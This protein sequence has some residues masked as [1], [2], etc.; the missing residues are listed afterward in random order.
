MNI[1]ARLICAA[2][3][4]NCHCRVEIK[5]GRIRSGEILGNYCRQTQQSRLEL[6]LCV[7]RELQRD[8]LSD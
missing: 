2:F 5:S 7:S 1:V 4:I 6:G 8:A 3:H